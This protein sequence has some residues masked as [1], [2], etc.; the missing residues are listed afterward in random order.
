MMMMIFYYLAMILSMLTMCLVWRQNCINHFSLSLTFWNIRLSTKLDHWDK[1]VVEYIVT[2]RTKAA[3]QQR[4][5]QRIYIYLL[6]THHLYILFYF[7]RGSIFL[8][9]PFWD[10]YFG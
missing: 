3:H 6:Q 4:T 1:W 7:L 10:V 9:F 2:W 5:D 8:S